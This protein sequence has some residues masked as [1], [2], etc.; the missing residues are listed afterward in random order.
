[1]GCADRGAGEMSLGGVD[2][3]EEFRAFAAGALEAFF[4]EQ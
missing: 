1:M 4:G 2:G 3:G